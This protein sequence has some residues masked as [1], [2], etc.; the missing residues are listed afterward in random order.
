MSNKLISAAIV[1]IGTTENPKGSN[2]CIF[3]DWYYGRTGVAASWCSTYVT[4]CLD[5]AGLLQDT[6]RAF[7]RATLTAITSGIRRL[8]SRI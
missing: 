6:W 1:Y 8:Q 4:K 2:K 7:S 3:N 5:D